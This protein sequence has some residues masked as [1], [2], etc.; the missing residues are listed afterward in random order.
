MEGDESEGREGGPAGTLMCLITSLAPGSCVA[1]NSS[2]GESV[3][4]KVSL[5]QKP[6]TGASGRIQRDVCSDPHA[7]D[8]AT[9]LCP[10]G[11]RASSVPH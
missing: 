1:A 2:L 10:P 8:G 3:F 9:R 5:L 11:S 4:T 6:L 7:G